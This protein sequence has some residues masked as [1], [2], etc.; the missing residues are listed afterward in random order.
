MKELK[1][2]QLFEEFTNTEKIEINEDLDYNEEE[3][4]INEELSNLQQ[5]YR[6]FFRCMLDCYDIK[7][8][9]SL[10]VSKKKEFFN[11][12][13][14]YWVKGKG[15]TKDLEDIKEEICGEENNCDKED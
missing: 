2:L 14:K 4:F 8:P 10:S 13:S 11:N 7:S 9:S 1:H 12:I 15:L 5:E 3:S 6:E